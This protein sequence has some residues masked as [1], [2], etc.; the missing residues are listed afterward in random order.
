MN[1]RIRITPDMQAYMRLH[2]ATMTVRDM[3]AELGIGPRSVES[4]CRGNGVV[5]LKKMNGK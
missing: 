4:W 2:A 3:A 1:K 5:P